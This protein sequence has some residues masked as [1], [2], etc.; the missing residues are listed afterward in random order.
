MFFLP[1]LHRKLIKEDWTLKPWHVL[2]GPL[3]LR[4]GEVPPP[5]VGHPVRVLQDYYRGHKTKEELVAQTGITP[6]AAADIEANKELRMAEGA[7]SDD[8]TVSRGELPGGNGVSLEAYE[9]ESW[10]RW[11][12]RPFVGPWYKPNNLPKALARVFM[13]GVDKDVVSAQKSKSPLS[14]NLEAVHARA[15]HFDNKTE[16]M[17]S[18]LQVL[19]AGAASF[20]HGA[21]DTANAMGPLST[22]YL[23]WNTGK[24]SSKAPV[25]LWVLAFGGVSIVIGLW[26][27]GYNIMRNLGN[28]ITLHSP[29]RGFSM[30]LGAALTVVMATRLALPIS[31]TQCI[32]GATVGVGLCT[33]DWRSVNWRMVLW[34]YLGWFITLPVAGLISGLLMA[35]II[36]A[37][38]FGHAL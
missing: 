14:G 15:P 12:Q 10:K 29:T 9:S 35:I 21:N 19:T 31:T 32:T 4:R 2:Y 1:Y 20:T 28:R 13:H 25:P 23:I 36:N 5:P 37:P 30:E 11:Y 8:Q 17:Y 33:G 38:Q 26:T 18:F 6:S 3:L 22:I 34:I 27:Y 7:D 24:L 16:H